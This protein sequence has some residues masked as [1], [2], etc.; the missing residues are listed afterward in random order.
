MDY[1]AR[2]SAPFDAELW[3]RI[4][5]TVVEAAKRV[6]VGRRFLPVFGPM[7][8]GMR[9]VNIDSSKREEK[10]DDGIVRTEGRVYAELPQ[11]YYDFWLLWRD[12]ENS[13][14]DGYPVDLSTVTQAAESVARTED[15][16]V[17]FGDKGLGVDG[18]LTARGANKVKR[19]DWK[20]GEFAY[21]DIVKGLTI[22]NDKG[23]YG[24]YAIIMSPDIFLDLQRIQPGTGVMEIDRV[25]KMV[26]G[27]VFHSTAM[28]TKKVVLVCCESPYMDIAI[29]QDMAASYL[30][31]VDLNHH[32]RVLETA[33]PRIK[34]AE[35]IVVFE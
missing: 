13:A 31:L 28:G 1:L 27:R 7:G 35:A 25:R 14:K 10:F 29:G 32:L 30:E 9:S 24:R 2:E 15:R 21:Q 34:Q 19:G 23:F 17:F 18:I 26:D 22:L 8:A 12:I 33:L 3:E 6:L 11:L 4:D 16:L 5:A 20:T